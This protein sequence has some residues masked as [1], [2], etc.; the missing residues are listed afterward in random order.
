MTVQVFVKSEEDNK[1]NLLRYRR[2]VA[3]LQLQLSLC[4]V[5]NAW[6]Q[7]VCTSPH[8]IC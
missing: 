8:K 7:S 6:S 4:D 1:L 5:F 3:I 2:C